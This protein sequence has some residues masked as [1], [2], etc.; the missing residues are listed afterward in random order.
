MGLGGSEIRDAGISLLLNRG[1]GE[2][3]PKEVTSAVRP[4]ECQALYAAVTIGNT[5]DLGEVSI[6]SLGQFVLAQRGGQFR[7]RWP[8]R[9]LVLS[10]Q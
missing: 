1:W 10:I 6:L 2:R 4:R 3:V 7:P 8:W 5:A 9:R